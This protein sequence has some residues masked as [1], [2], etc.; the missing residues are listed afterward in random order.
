M[1]FIRG[2]HDTDTLTAVTTRCQRSTATITRRASAYTMSTGADSLETVT[3]T[4]HQTRGTVVYARLSRRC[5]LRSSRNMLEP[6]R[7]HESGNRN[8]RSVRK[9]LRL[10][11]GESAAD[12]SELGYN[13]TFDLWS[14]AGERLPPRSSRSR[15]SGSKTGSDAVRDCTASDTDALQFRG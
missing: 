3:S 8:P 1:E 9:Q 4:E 10:F 11:D 5:L 6:A 12:P 2:V 15:P 7:V 14:T 13:P